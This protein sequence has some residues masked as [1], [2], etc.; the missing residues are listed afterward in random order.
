MCFGMGRLAIALVAVV[1]GCAGCAPA[2]PSPLSIETSWARPGAAPNPLDF[3][4]EDVPAG[5]TVRW[6]EGAFTRPQIDSMADGQCAAV[7]RVAHAEGAT[8]ASAGTLSQFFRCEPGALSGLMSG[9]TS[10]APPGPR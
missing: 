7:N 3:P 9:S 2:G 1:L 10:P 8:T 4:T 6:R 5:V